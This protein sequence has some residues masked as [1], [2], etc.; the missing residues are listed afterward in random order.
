MSS[1][2]VTETPKHRLT[3]QV[4]LLGAG[5]V[6]KSL[7]HLLGRSTNNVRITVAS[8]FLDEAREVASAAALG[9]PV[10]LDVYRDSKRL[11]ELVQEADLV[12]SL[13]PA[14]MHPH[15][16]DKCIL[17]K[18]HLVT[19]SYESDEMRDMHHRAKEAGIIILNE[20]GLD[21]G[22]DHM[23]AMKIIDN[24]QARGGSVTG[25]S[26][27]CGGLPA[28]ET[29]LD[30]KS[31][32]ALKYKFSWNPRGVIRA[33]QNDARY[34][35]QGE[36]T[37]IYG[38]ELLQTA[39]PFLDAWPHLK[40]ECLPNRDSLVY[41]KAYNIPNA[42]TV[43]RGTLRYDGFS[44]LMDVF[45]NMGLFESTPVEQHENWGDVMDM[46]M[47]QK[48]DGSFESIIDFMVSCANDDA[49]K[50]RLAM[51]TLEWLGIVD[52]NATV[53]QPTVVDAFCKV[54]QEKLRYEEGERDMVVMHH[55]I[56]ATFDDGSEERHLSS[57]TVF[58]DSLASAMSKT[59]VSSP[60]QPTPAMTSSSNALFMLICFFSQGYT[61][62]AAAELILF[63]S[64]TEEAA[65]LLLPTNKA[66]YHPILARM[67]QE[68]IGFVDTVTVQ[69]RSCVK[70]A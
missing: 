1:W 12:I 47:K 35:R 55:T 33:S 16:A 19:A 43:F 61:A 36:M 45:Q 25:F 69:S 29:A 54:M 34:R 17:H 64:L 42:T 52:S 27:V 30:D 39:A 40:L 28:P 49:D 60:K 2:S 41:E 59:V 31:K 4:L 9:H 13:L 14:T 50:A 67:K 58:G 21:P 38:R 53:E 65:G 15:V 7:V 3:K 46:L 48:G 20:V 18:V 8:A 44:S 6:S 70:Q 22:L 51:E 57:L 10:A 26:S 66:I 68:G 24:I 62:A 23:S 5:R 32:N 56:E 37:E 11:S 63:G